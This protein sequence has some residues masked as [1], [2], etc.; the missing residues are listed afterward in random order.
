MSE[1]QSLK[2]LIHPFRVVVSPFKAF[3][4]ITQNPSLLGFLLIVGLNSLAAASGEFIRA[5][6]IILVDAENQ[7]AS[8]LNSMFFNQSLILVLVQSALGFLL[9]WMI[10]AGVLFFVKRI[11]SVK[12]VSL[13]SFFIIVGY[14][15][16]ALVMYSAVAALLISTLPQIQFQMSAWTSETPDD[17][18]NVNTHFQEVWGPTLASQVVGYLGLAFQV[19]L[20]ILGS[21]AV[22][23]SSEIKWGN[24][25]IS[26]VIAYFASILLTSFL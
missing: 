12:S 4:D 19:W 1:H 7:S 8:L 21:I 25:F 5:S 18:A 23:T 9:I 20:V 6:K 16:I 26:S 15:F 11:F 22:H 2:S 14:A 10:Y 17:V 3:R 13:R 24:A